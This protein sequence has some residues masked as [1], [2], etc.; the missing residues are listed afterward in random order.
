M[1]ILYITES[2]MVS[3]TINLKNISNNHS[4]HGIIVADI[5]IINLKNVNIDNVK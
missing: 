1:P 5:A 3:N 4:L 2:S